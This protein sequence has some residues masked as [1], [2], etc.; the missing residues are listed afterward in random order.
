M[1]HHT[2]ITERY[3]T[4]AAIH[5]LAITRIDAITRAKRASIS[6]IAE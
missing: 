4:V 2:I 5:W 6:V 1:A 3:R